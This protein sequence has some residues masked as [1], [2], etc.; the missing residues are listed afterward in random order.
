VPNG[1]L[2]IEALLKLKM[3]LQTRGFADG[4]GV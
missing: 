4:M 3:P 2:G 1:Y